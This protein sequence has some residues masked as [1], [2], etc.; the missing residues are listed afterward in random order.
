[1]INRKKT[2]I[3]NFDFEEEAAIGYNK[4]TIKYHGNKVKT[5]FFYEA[6]FQV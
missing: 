1:M 5:N 4:F 2:Y 6:Y 3:V